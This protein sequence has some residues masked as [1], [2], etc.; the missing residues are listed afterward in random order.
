M[1]FWLRGELTDEQNAVYAIVNTLTSL[2]WCRR[3]VM[4]VNGGTPEGKLSYAT[5]FMR[6]MDYRR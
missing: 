6:S 4:T 5:P 3:V 2:S 1:G